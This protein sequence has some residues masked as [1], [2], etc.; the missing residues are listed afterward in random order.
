MAEPGPPTPYID[1]ARDDKSTA[2]GSTGEESA[3]GLE[4]SLA[5][6]QIFPC[7]ICGENVPAELHGKYY[8][9]R[10]GF[11]HKACYNAGHALSRMCSVDK[12]LA[13]NV[14]DMKTKDPFKH[15]AIILSLVTDDAYSRTRSQR[16]RSKEFVTELSSE[17][18]VAKHKEVVMLPESQFVAWYM[19]NENMSKESAEQKWR[20]D[21]NNPDI[22]REYDENRWVPQP[23]V[24][25][26]YCVH[27]MCTHANVCECVLAASMYALR[28]CA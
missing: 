17:T 22:K 27:C 21:Y 11:V 10:K 16:Q 3:L 2:Q 23:H 4:C 26:T 19:H 6:Q 9:N 28:A 18:S 15:K 5:S 20:D 12:D 24:Y 7:E 1:L 13:K 8:S 25:I 14:N